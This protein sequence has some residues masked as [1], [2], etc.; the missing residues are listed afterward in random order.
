M[1]RLARLITLVVSFASLQLSL[2]SGGPGCPLPG[3]MD[4]SSAAMNMSSAAMDMSPAE[5]NMSS[6]AMSGASAEAMAGMDMAGMDMATTAGSGAG[7]APVNPGAAAPQAPCDSSAPPNTCPTMAP[8]VF[9]SVPASTRLSS[10]IE[11][12]SYA[13]ALSTTMPY[14]LSSPPDVPP[15]RA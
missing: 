4:M 5:M 11:E 10:S 15:P 2:A 14:S 13:V 6:A 7:E 1:V 8:C 12:P 9:A 3:A